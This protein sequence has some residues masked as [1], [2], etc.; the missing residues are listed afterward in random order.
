M[1]AD[2]PP[3]VGIPE[4]LDRRMRLGPFAS[5][6]DALK[7][8]TY[9]AASAVLLPVAGA[10]AWIPVVL[11]AFVVSVWRP[12]G[13][14]IDRRLLAFARWKGRALRGP[15]ASVTTGN[16]DPGPASLL[17]LPDGRHAAVLRSAGLPLAYLPPSELA[18]RFELFRELLRSLEGAVLF[19]ASLAPI[20]AGSILPHGP[21]SG[22]EEGAREGYRELV[23]LIARR[24]W[25]RQVYVVRTTSGPG[26]SPAGRLEAELDG[27][28][29]RLAAIGL[30][31]VRLRGRALR[32][33][34]RR[35]GL[36]VGGTGA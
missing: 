28:G 19:R 35:I 36:S 30:S 9:A 32:D 20:H 12:D 5:G 2:G 24:R 22:A 31:P 15:G 13:E 33:A 26:A 10:E 6:R 11:A 4:R 16:D 25:V 29:E 23:E 27:L 8:V 1:A 3:V 18:R 17:R 21:A 14:A 34:A 7:F